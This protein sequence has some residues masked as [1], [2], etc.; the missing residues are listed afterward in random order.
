VGT[1]DVVD[2][3]HPTFE[4]RHRIE[5]ETAIG[6]TNGCSFILPQN[7]EKE[8]RSSNHHVNSLV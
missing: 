5:Y 1:F 3:M 6:K 2:E 4:T 7:D 8:L